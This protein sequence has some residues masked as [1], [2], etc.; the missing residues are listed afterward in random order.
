M[1]FYR[2]PL[3]SIWPSHKISEV[4][5]PPLK[6]DKQLKSTLKI[7]EWGVYGRNPT[8]CP[9][10]QVENTRQMEKISSGLHAPKFLSEKSKDNIKLSTDGERKKS[11]GEDSLEKSLS[12]EKEDVPVTYQS[13]D[14]K[15][16][17]YGVADFDF[18]LVLRIEIQLE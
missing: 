10:N 11:L 6:I 7:A 18:G 5:A 12:S 3:L 4:G 9:R 13:L 17:K 15:Y 8:T 2:E 1:P 16:S 14:I